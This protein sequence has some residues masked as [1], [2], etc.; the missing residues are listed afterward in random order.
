MIINIAG[1][2]GSGKT[3]TVRQLLS[4][5]PIKVPEFT[6]GRK[7]P[8]GYHFTVSG[9][10][11][12]VYLV[13]AYEEA[14]TGG[15]DSIKDIATI[16]D[17]VRRKHEAKYHVVYEGLFMMNMTRGPQLVRACP[18][19]VNVMKLTTPL[20]DCF[21]GINARRAAKGQPPLLKRENTEGNFKRADNYWRV[22][23][24]AGATVHKVSRDE[25]FPKM[26]ELLRAT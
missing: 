21:A 17:L 9:V 8:L 26:L 12:G 18:G 23:R 20:E 15:C 2:S 24:D 25:A 22:M 1:T 19:A 4:M 14:A 6:P 16:Y 7:A 10:T 11:N 5:V 3:T 13:G